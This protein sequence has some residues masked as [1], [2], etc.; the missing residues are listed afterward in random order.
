MFKKVDCV[1]INVQHIDKALEFYRY[2]LGLELVW[3]KGSDEAGLRMSESDS[4]IVL[5]KDEL[6]YPEVD[7]TVES[8][9]NSVKKFEEAGGKVIVKPF[10]IA[11][12][13]CSV[14]EDP[15]KNRFVILDNSKGLLKVDKD[16]NVV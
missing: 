15:W 9:E 12:G 13:K 16:K 6:E 3:K 4:E 14:V 5:I 8:V 7:L 10:E 1:R 2:K 11:I